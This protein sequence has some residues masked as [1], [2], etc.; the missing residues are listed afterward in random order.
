MDFRNEPVRSIPKYREKRPNRKKKKLETFLGVTIRPK[1]VRGNISKK[2]YQ[3]A[4][5]AF[6]ECCIIC[7]GYPIEMHH[8]TFRSKSGRSG[9]RNLAPLCREHHN[10]AHQKR[11]FADLLRDE[12]EEMF[13]PFYAADKWDLYKKNLIP[14]CTDEAYEKFMVAE[15]KKAA[16]ND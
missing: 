6:G 8:C 2:D 11:K 10:L 1:R 13:G 16:K 15:E 14:N 4:I 7:N 9:Y 12:R 5:E 3:E